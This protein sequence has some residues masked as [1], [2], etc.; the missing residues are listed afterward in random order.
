MSHE[1]EDPDLGKL[2]PARLEVVEARRSTLE[3]LAWQTPGF[4]FAGQAFLLTIVLNPATT[5]VGRLLASIAGFA[6]AMAVLHF[7]LDCRGTEEIHARWVNA[8]LQADG[9]ADLRYDTLEKE[10]REWAGEEWAPGWLDWRVTRRLVLRPRGLWV[11]TA[12][13]A[14]FVLLDLLLVIGAIVEVAGG[15]SLVD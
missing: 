3:Q 13:L 15:G 12:G 8:R 1:H 11:W 6:A 7:Y 14:V 10:V 5:G 4:S 9:T 2:A